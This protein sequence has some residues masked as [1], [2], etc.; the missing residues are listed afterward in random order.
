MNL[1]ALIPKLVLMSVFGMNLINTSRPVAQSQSISVSEGQS[2]ALT[3]E[4]TIIVPFIFGTSGVQTNQSYFGSI[5]VSVAGVGQASG[6]EWSDAFYIYT[7]SAGQPVEPY[8][9][10]ELY[11]FTLWIDGGPA[12]NMVKSI[13]P[14]NEK[15]TYTFFIQGSGSPL[16][17]AVGD[18]YTIDNSG[19]YTITVSE[20]FVC[21]VPIVENN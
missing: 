11:N 12:D 8:H 7:N 6:T 21:Y 1:Y 18:L 3:V 10:I 20:A 2:S 17:F 14:Y 4:E 15:H 19:N 5:A 16:N 13:P 9:P